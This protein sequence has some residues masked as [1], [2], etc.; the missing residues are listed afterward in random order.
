MKLPT[1]EQFAQIAPGLTT[2]QLREHFGICTT[3][4]RELRKETGIMSPKPEAM[5]ADFKV[6]APHLT[7]LK[8]CARWGAGNKKIARWYKEAGL[9]PA[10]YKASKRPPVP[11]HSN[12]GRPAAAPMAVDHS[13]VG[14]V[15]T[16]LRRKFPSVHRMTVYEPTSSLRRNL[17]GKAEDYYMVGARVMHKDALWGLARD[18]G[19]EG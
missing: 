2:K 9:V 19:W 3:Y 11:G 5:P 1:P 7:L 15:V 12:W 18:L 8:A 6:A 4:V 16:F 10:G 17:P 14:N 13:A